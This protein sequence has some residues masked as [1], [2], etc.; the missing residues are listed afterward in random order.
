MEGRVAEGE[1]CQVIGVV[2]LLRRV[3][4][5]GMVSAL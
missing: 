1:R 3:S 5:G 2:Q 4:L